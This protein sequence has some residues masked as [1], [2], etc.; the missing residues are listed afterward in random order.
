MTRSYGDRSSV[1]RGSLWMAHVQDRLTTSTTFEEVQWR[2]PLTSKRHHCV[3]VFLKSSMR[4][5]W[6]TSCEGKV[7]DS[8]R[9]C[10]VSTEI[11]LP[12]YSVVSRDTL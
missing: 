2:R 9:P 1:E 11:P 4:H 3:D 6:N 8:L 10:G 7:L 12:N 5:K